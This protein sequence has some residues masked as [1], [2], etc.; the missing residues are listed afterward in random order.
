[1]FFSDSVQ[2]VKKLDLEPLPNV[3]TPNNDQH[4]QAFVLPENLSGASLEIYNRWGNQVYLN[5]EYKNDWN[6][7]AL[8]SGVYFYHISHRCLDHNLKGT[9]SIIRS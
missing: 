5:Q 3:I 2:I 9:I 4:N 8:P 6:G 7:E 1:V